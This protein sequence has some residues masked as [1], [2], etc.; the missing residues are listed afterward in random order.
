MINLFKKKDKATDPVCL[1]KV[2]KGEKAITYNYKEETYYFCSA[3]CKEQFK[4]DPE[5]FLS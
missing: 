2:E 4:K 1:M 3:N 5:Q